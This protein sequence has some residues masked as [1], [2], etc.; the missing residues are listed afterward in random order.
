MCRQIKNGPMARDGEHEASDQALLADIQA[1][2]PV[3]LRQFIDRYD[4]LVRYTV[5]QQSRHRANRDPNWLDAV[6]SE[7]WTDFCRSTA[8]GKLTHVGNIPAYIIQSARFRCIDALRRAKKGPE[9]FGGDS[10]EIAGAQ[11]IEDKAD[12]DGLLESLEEVS[13]L[14]SCMAALPPADK[15][16]CAEIELITTGKWKETAARLGIPESTLRSRWSRVLERLKK[17]MEKN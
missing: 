11:L 3:A 15:V 9:A 17:C 1:G 16:L 13:D 7:F 2:Q 5:Y 8:A 6:A 10:D 4:K 12:T 14:R